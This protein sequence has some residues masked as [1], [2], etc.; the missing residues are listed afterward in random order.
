MK[1]LLISIE[2]EERGLYRRG[3]RRIQV[4]FCCKLVGIEQFPPLDC[5]L[6]LSLIKGW[7]SMKK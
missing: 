5:D 4:K 6:G 2:K 3:W 7:G 1:W